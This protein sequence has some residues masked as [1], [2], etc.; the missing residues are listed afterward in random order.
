M[1]DTISEYEGRLP[2]KIIGEARNSLPKGASDAKIKKIMEAVYSEYNDAKVHPGES[3]GLI[4]AE[5][6]GEPGTQMSLDYEEKVILKNQNK[7]R[8]IKIGEFVDKIMSKKI[9]YKKQD[10]TEICD[11]DSA[12]LYVPALSHNERIEWKKVTALSRHKSPKNLLRIKTRS[13]R[14]ITATPYHSFVIRKDNDITPVA[15]FDLKIGDRIPSVRKIAN[16]TNNDFLKLEDYLPKSQ[17]IYESE[18]RKAINKEKY[19]E[20]PIKSYEQINNYAQG[21]VKFQLKQNCVYMLQN[22]SAGQIPEILELDYLFG[23]FIGSYLAEG[24]HTENYIGI[25]NISEQ[26]L[27]QIITFAEKYNINYKI[28]YDVGQYGKSTTLLLYSTLIADLINKTCGK[29]SYGK[30]IPEFAY[31]AKSEFVSGLLGAYFDGDGN[32]NVLRRVIRAS[33]CSKQLIDGIAILLSQFGIFAVKSLDNKNQH[34]LSISYRYANQFK[35]KINLVVP[36]KKIALEKLT[37]IQGS[38]TSYDLI[39]MISGY[40]DILLRLGKK[41]GIP[42]RLTNKFTKKQRI[43][44]QALKKYIAIFENA[45]EEKNISIDAELKILKIMLNSDV[46]WDDIIKLQTVKPTKEFVYDFSVEDLETFTTFDGIVTHNTLNT[47]H[48]AGVAEMNVTLGLP[49][50]IEILDGRK[51]LDN[52]MMEIYLKKPYATGKRIEDLRQLAL[53]IKE[54]KLKDIATEFIIN[55]ADFT[56]EIKLDKEKMKEI[57]LT[58]GKV[59]DAVSKQLKGYNIKDNKDVITL[60]SRS[61]EETFNEAYKTKEKIKEI[62]V[63]GVKGI[64]QVLPVKREDE[65]IIIT[66]GSNLAEVLQLEEVDA[67]RTTTN[68]IFE[69]EQVLGIEA[70]RQAIVNEIFKVIESQGLNVDVRHIMLVADTMC[71]SGTLKGITRYGVVSEKSSV[72]ARASFETPIKHIINAALVGE[73]DNLDSVVE[74]VMINQPVPIGTGLPSLTV[75]SPEKKGKEK[76]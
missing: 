19:F 41:L 9:H 49:R 56:I 20:L 33:S 4:S 63:K 75:K 25:S 28:R 21:N 35:E 67:Y 48:F 54:T 44:R 27:K 61:K 73:M 40:G 24:T 39:D 22:H 34:T 29:K 15:G 53:Q 11:L 50:I 70:A 26:Y 31:S 8:I 14:H 37:Q 64:L 76:S 7:V 66:A 13:G 47:F 12:E 5:S 42:S 74:N 17:Y 6:I 72:L 71:V 52:P 46:I 1:A 57:E 38:K 32:I 58:L 23:F 60:K 45:S 68:N 65:F 2:S 59:L 16:V 43:G 36:R 62:N 51:E 10:S 30:Y 55:I 3:V 69:I 18:L